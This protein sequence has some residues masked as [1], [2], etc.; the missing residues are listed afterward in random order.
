MSSF[1]IAAGAAAVTVC[2]AGAAT[3]QSSYGTALTLGV[4][5]YNADGLDATGTTLQSETDLSFGNVTLDIDLGWDRASD[6]G[7]DVSN[8]STEILPKYWFSQS[9][10]AGVYFSRD[11]L[12]LDVG[13]VVNLDSYG[14]EGTYRSAGFEGSAFVGRTDADE[15]AG[16]LDIRDIGLRARFDASPQLSLFGSG[17]RSNFEAGGDD[18]N[19][20]S[21]GLGAHY[22]FGNGFAMFGGYQSTSID[23][24]DA[25]V[26]TASVGVNYALNAGG[27]P[28]ILSGEYARARFDAAGFDESADRLSL[29]ATV[30]FGDAR[31][32]RVP[33]NAVTSPLLKSD[34]NAVSGLISG[35]GF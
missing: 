2:L 8:L 35:I 14:I 13:D 17:V 30:L 16:D 26:G 24:V 25:E 19:A 31:E 29:S 33:G 18:V 7:I 32:K 20:Y 10:G 6:D 3:A 22:D 21:L 11:S 12:D 9:A 28:V 15:L 27:T 23:D 34:R 5:N 1:S 4:N